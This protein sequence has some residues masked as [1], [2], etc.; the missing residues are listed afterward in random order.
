MDERD[1]LPAGRTV[2]ARRIWS[3]APLPSARST[4]SSGMTA[5]SA[6]RKGRQAVNSTGRGLFSGGRQRTALAMR[7]ST[8]RS[9]S[10]GIGAVGARGEAELQQGRVE[11]VAGI[12]A[13]EGPA[14]AVGALHAGRQADD[15]QARVELAEGAD[16]RILPVGILALQLVAEGRRAW[17]SADSRAAALRSLAQ[18]LDRGGLGRPH[19]RFGRGVVEIVAIAPRAG[20]RRGRGGALR[21]VAGD[22]R[23]QLGRVR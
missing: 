20:P 14:G 13:G 6:C 2:S 5:S 22:Q 23:R 11:E 16:R 21:R 15:Q 18:P 19:Q 9:P 3:C 10:F 17:D 12:V 7:Q 1:R 8:R 4:R